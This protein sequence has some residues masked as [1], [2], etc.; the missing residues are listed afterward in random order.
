MT[1]FSRRAVL[2]GGA[3]GAIVAPF[4]HTLAA[5][6]PD[7]PCMS[8]VVNVHD[9]LHID[10]SAN[11]LL[12]VC[13]LLDAA[14]VR[15]D[16]YLTAPMADAYAAQRTDVIAALTR[17]TISYHIRAPHPLVPGFGR[18][19]RDLDATAL[20]TA[21]ADAE[22]FAQDPLTGELIRARVGGFAR[23]A[24]VFGR[25]PVTVGLPHP[26]PRIRAAACRHYASVGARVVVWYHESGTPVDHPW[27]WHEGLLARPSDFSVTRWGPHDDFWWN[28]VGRKPEFDPAAHL[29]TE[30]ARWSASRQPFVTSLI[31]ENNFPRSGAESWTLRYYSDWKKSSPLPP[32]WSLS[33]A[34]PSKPRDPADRAAIWSAYERL[35]AYAAAHT[36]VIT[37]DDL[38]GLAAA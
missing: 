14:D 20:A 22:R 17:H 36:R 32:P 33:A 13:K 25:A 16:F 9:T 29:Q 24:E 12:R 18:H 38:P 4:A 8:F 27:E 1:A 10:E 19:F 35:I 6:L 3:A 15:G 31:H 37:S 26:D 30:L 21:I 11:T 28:R 23:V 7:R 2:V 34:D 5:T